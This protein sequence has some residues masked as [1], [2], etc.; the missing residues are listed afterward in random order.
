M[1]DSIRDKLVLVVEDEE[2][3]WLLIKEFL[4]IYDVQS[5]WVE[6]GMAALEI[7]K[8]QHKSIA[9]VMLDMKLPMMTGYETAPKMKSMYPNIPII[10]Q[11]A[12]AQPE[13]EEKCFNVGCDG[14]I[15]KPFTLDEMTEVILKTLE[16]TPV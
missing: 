15:S 3:N 10:A 4:D 8:E 7:L 6:T 1:F 14:Y 13:D 16:K 11:T 12:H 9:F 2:H 5:I